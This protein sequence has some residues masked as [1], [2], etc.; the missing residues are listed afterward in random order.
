MYKAVA[1]C[2]TFALTGGVLPATEAVGST[3]T[4]DG[5]AKLRGE[6]NG[7]NSTIQL[8][9]LP[10]RSQQMNLSCLGDHRTGYMVLNG[11]GCLK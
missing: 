2:V 6:L 11:E 9:F 3:Q 8:C 4:W 1:I 5:V 7:L 10:G